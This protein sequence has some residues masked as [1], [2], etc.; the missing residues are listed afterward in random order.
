MV[1]RSDRSARRA[2]TV[3]KR[4]DHLDAKLVVQLRAGPLLDR[5]HARVV[6]RIRT[7]ARAQRAVRRRRREG[8]HR[9]RR[10]AGAADRRV[11]AVGRRRRAALSRQAGLQPADQ[12][13]D[14][15]SL[16][17]IARLVPA[18]AGIKLQPAFEVKAD[19]PLDRLGIEMN[20]RS[21]AGEAWRQ[22][23]R[24]T[25]LTPGQ[26]AVGQTCRSRHLDLAADSRQP[27][28]EERHHGRHEIGRPRARRS[29]NLNTLRG[30]LEVRF[31]ASGR[32]RLRGRARSNAE[33][34]ID[35]RRV[36]ARRARRCV[37][38]ERDRGRDA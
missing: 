19:G 12:S 7:G 25:S 31:A 20:V 10:E 4:F 24:P 23:R 38:R 22:A 13:S 36:G 29:P 28:A 35:G 30:T 9:V 27:G 32:G 2:S 33:A 8:R 11:V 26:S 6:P 14:K 1:D 17:E 15:L 37:R 21:S 34:K 18:L 16:P 5:D 3:P